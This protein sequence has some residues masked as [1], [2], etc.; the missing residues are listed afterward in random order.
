V[1]VGIVETELGWPRLGWELIQ[2]GNLGMQLLDSSGG[3]FDMT[4]L[5]SSLFLVYNCYSFMGISGC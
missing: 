4:L 3:A 2:H 5:H 1:F